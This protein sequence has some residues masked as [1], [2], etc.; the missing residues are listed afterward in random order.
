V[1]RQQRQP[2]SHFNYNHRTG[3]SVVKKSL[4]LTLVFV[5]VIMASGTLFAAERSMVGNW[6]ITF[7][8]FYGNEQIGTKYGQV[9]VLFHITKQKGRS[10]AGTVDIDGQIGTHIVTG[11]IKNDKLTMIIGGNTFIRGNAYD[12]AN[13]TRLY[14]VMETQRM[15]SDDTQGV[16]DGTASKE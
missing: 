15:S 7:K 1:N 9:E 6:T 13:G 3:G 2:F 5:S 16:L 10:F 12:T 8:G 14:L 4:L 11:N